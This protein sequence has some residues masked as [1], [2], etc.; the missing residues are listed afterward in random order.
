MQEMTKADATGP[1]PNDGVSRR[2]VLKG[3][4]AAG[5][6]TSGTGRALAQTVATFDYV[7]VGSGPGGGPL[8]CNLARAGYSVCLMEAGG[9]ATA[10]DLVEEMAIPVDNLAVTADPRVAWSYF[11]RHYADQAQQERDSKFVP[12]ENG[13][14][15]PRASTIGGCAV[16]NALMSVYPSNSDWQ[17][18]V[19]LTGDPSWA[20]DLMRGYFQR[21]EACGYRTPSPETELVERHGFEGWQ[22]TELPDPQLFLDDPQ[23]KR[24]IEAAQA[25][26]GQP[27]DV[28][29]FAQE[30]LDPNDYVSTLEDR[31]G[32]YTIPLSRKDGARQ[33][34][35]DR[36]LD[37]VAAC[38]NLTVL[39]NSLASRILLDEDNV[40]VGVEYLPGANL[41]RASPLAA[42][43]AAPA[44]APL[45]VHARREVVIAAGTFNSPQLLKLSG[46]GDPAELSALGIPV[47]VDRPGV[48]T[49]MM[50]RYEVAVVT[51]L[52]Q[53]ITLFAACGTGATDPCLIAWAQNKGIYTTTALSV[54]GFV[55]SSPDQPVRN[56]VLNENYGNFH[57]Y[58][59]G[60]EL[61]V[62]V[63][64]NQTWLLLKAHNKNRAGT[65]TLRSAD[66]RDTP[67]IDFHYF[68]EGTDTAGDDLRAVVD[69]VLLARRLNEQTADL[70]VTELLPGPSV[71]TEADIATWVRDEAWGHHASCSNHMGPS[72]DPLAVVDSEFRVYGTRNLRIVDASVFPRIPGY[73]LTIPIQMISEKASDVI[74]A[75]ARASGAGGG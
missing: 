41:Y 12:A 25:V 6:L 47:R 15:Y 65:V 4:G 48:G 34:V 57:G 52:K 42:A 10:P 45:R 37:T 43:T 58:Y 24:F 54:S 38:P 16:H 21:M 61:T 33:T 23:T 46:I 18:I 3:L 29:G 32:V 49:G 74:L 69:G 2:T 5:V 51:E 59:P 60:Y 20:P 71:R 30:R 35:R 66:P 73:Y 13:I 27:G 36:I 8:A 67:A 68:E 50:D 11:V 19:D 72:S 55:K 40:A 53:P 26:I 64:T 28:Q 63:P 31:Q 22:S 17:H 7:V 44:P 1:G 75:A 14:L 70:A 9:P 62:G 56:L 39:T